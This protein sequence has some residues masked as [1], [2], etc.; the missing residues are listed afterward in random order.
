ML[1]KFPKGTAK[2]QGVSYGLK[3]DEWQALAAL[4]YYL[5]V[6]DVKEI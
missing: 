3:E 4:S 2:K 1:K 6:L 5:E